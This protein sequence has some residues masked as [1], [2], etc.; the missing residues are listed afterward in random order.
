[1]PEIQA[2]E[3]SKVVLYLRCGNTFH[4]FVCADVLRIE[5]YLNDPRLSSK[6]K[7]EDIGKNFFHILRT[8]A[9]LA[10][11]LFFFHQH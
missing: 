9:S 2:A 10:D 3:S 5:E 8:S 6:V 11:V 7:I 1:V 4:F